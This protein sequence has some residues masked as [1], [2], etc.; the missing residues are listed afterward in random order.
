MSSVPS[1]PSDQRAG[2]RGEHNVVAWP[3]QR[4]AVERQP[5]DRRLAQLAPPRIPIPPPGYGGIELVLAG[6]WPT[7]WTTRAR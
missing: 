2:H 6:P 4:T 1:E 3:T 5:E 7:G